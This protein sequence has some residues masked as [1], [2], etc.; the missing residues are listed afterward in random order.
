MGLGLGL[1]GCGS[2]GRDLGKAA[3]EKVTDA[4]LTAAFD[5]YRP[6]VEAFCAEYRALWEAR[7]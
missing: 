7:P 3:E 6:N 2:M 1:I 5:P 4:K